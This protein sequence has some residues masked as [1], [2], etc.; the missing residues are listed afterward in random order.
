ME[1]I[2]EEYEQKR[3]NKNDYMREYMRKRN[4]KLKQQIQQPTFE[5]QLDS[6]PLEFDYNSLNN[7]FQMLCEVYKQNVKHKIGK[8]IKNKEDIRNHFINSILFILNGGK[9]IDRIITP[10]GIIPNLEDENDIGEENEVKYNV[11]KDEEEGLV[12]NNLTPIKQNIENDDS[13]ET[14]EDDSEY[15]LVYDVEDDTE[16]DERQDTKRVIEQETQPINL[17][18]YFKKKLYKIWSDYGK[19]K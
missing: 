18:E 5:F 14:D 2:S 16:D 13:E 11:R 19:S 3:K 12:D 17:Y 9:E 7:F 15:T 4:Q 10:Y 1:R 6:A 8:Y